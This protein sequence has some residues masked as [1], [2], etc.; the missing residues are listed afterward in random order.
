MCQIIHDAVEYSLKLLVSDVPVRNFFVWKFKVVLSF[1]LML[2]IFI[3]SVDSCL[4]P[5]FH[6]DLLHAL[7]L[8]CITHVID[9]ILFLNFLPHTLSCLCMGWWQDF[10]FEYRYLHSISKHPG[11]RFNLTGTWFS[12]TRRKKWK[13]A[14]SIQLYLM[15]GYISLIVHKHCCFPKAI[16]VL[17]TY[18]HGIGKYRLIM[19]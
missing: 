7:Y 6:P 9:A 2:H 18:L 3:T 15:S 12:L 17:S 11:S 19:Y 16:N 8:H 1:W 4:E 14:V 13:E 10:A 5:W